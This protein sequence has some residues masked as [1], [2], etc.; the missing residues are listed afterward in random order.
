VLGT[1]LLATFYATYVSYRGVRT[2]MGT[3]LLV[4]K[5]VPAGG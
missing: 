1:L 5:A 4:G 3:M 2:V